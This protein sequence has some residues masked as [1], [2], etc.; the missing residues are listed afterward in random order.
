MHRKSEIAE[1]SGNTF[2]ISQPKHATIQPILIFYLVFI[3]F[4]VR[5]CESA[6]VY[7]CCC[8]CPGLCMQLFIGCTY[9]RQTAAAPLRTVG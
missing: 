9:Y 4:I 2:H 1:I 3:V 8:K 7:H 5:I 6:F